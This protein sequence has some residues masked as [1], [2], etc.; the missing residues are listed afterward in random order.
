MNKD[1]DRE[2][3]QNVD[4][5]LKE[6][7]FNSKKHIS[8]NKSM[9]IKTDKRYVDYMTDIGL[10]KHIN[11]LWGAEYDITLDTKGFEVFEKYKNWYDYKKKV[12]DKKQKTEEAKSIVQRY[13]WVTIVISALSLI[14][15]VLALFCVYFD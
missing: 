10:I 13:W 14:I 1:Y 5:I 8:G 4:K 11:L 3:N 12:L 2:F 9:I 7:Y 6:L 15:A